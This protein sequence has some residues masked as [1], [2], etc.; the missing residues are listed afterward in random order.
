MAI[1]GIA[2]TKVTNDPRGEINRNFDLVVSQMRQLAGLEILNGHIVDAELAGSAADNV[3]DHKLGRAIIGWMVV[4]Q[5]AGAVVYRSPTVADDTKHL[6]LRT[7]SA[8]S[9][10][11]WVF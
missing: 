3:I 2:T 9:V 5:D 6:I 10:R 1:R 4:D 11:L 7:S 8:Q